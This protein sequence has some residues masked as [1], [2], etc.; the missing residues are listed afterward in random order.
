MCD[1]RCE[2][3]REKAATSFIYGAHLSFCHPYPPSRPWQ[4]LTHLLQTGVADD[5]EVL[6]G[7]LGTILPAVHRLCC[8]P[9]NLESKNSVETYAALLCVAF[10]CAR[11]CVGMRVRVCDLLFAVPFVFYEMLVE[12]VA[13]LHRCRVA[14]VIPS[15]GG[16]LEPFFLWQ[17]QTEF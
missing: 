12:V 17:S 10:F 2:R 6:D 8:T 15:Q 14:I 7:S 13:S 16:F 11:V 5:S 4:G 9:P 3:E 1:V